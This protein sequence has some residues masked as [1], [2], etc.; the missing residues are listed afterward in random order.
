MCSCFVVVDFSIVANIFLLL[1][2]HLNSSL[3]A[4]H[5]VSVSIYCLHDHYGKFLLFLATILRA[6]FVVVTCK[7]VQ[8]ESGQ[9]FFLLLLLL[10][11]LAV[12]E[13]EV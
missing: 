3:M 8:F 9:F 1:L 5:S 11:S 7:Q 13:F 4:V 12:V 2:L 6:C 10:L